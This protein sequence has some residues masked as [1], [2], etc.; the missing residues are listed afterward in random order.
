MVYGK[1]GLDAGGMKDLSGLANIKVGGDGSGSWVGYSL[2]EGG[3]GP[4]G[5]GVAGGA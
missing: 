5:C 3:A 2:Q 4:M 1:S